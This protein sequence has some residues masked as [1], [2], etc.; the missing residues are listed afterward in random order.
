MTLFLGVDGGGT[1][2]EFVL[3]EADGKVVARALTGTTYHLQVGLDVAVARLEEGIAAVC[4]EAGIAPGDLGHAFFGLPAFGE[5]AAIDPLLDAACGRLLGHDRYACDNDMVCGWAGSLA[6]ADG[7]NLVAGTGS[8]GYGER[9]GR[10]ARAGGWGEV[11]SDEGSAYWIAVQGLNLFTR[12]SDGRLTKTPLWQAFRDA[13]KLP[14]DLDICARVMGDRGM[15]RD[16]I[17]GLA[18]LVSRAA[19]A[20]DAHALAVLDRAGA[21]LAAIAQALREQL[22]FAVEET[23]LLSWSGG[24]LTNLDAVR[25]PFLDSLARAGRYEVVAP[26]HEPGVGA[27]LYAVLLERAGAQKV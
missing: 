6:C 12:M 7:I 13:L 16:E 5:D 14:K 26:L 11:F 20:G 25:Q 2:T 23:V 21:E 27:A 17:A 3:I 19:Q 22:G 10:K 1:K 18:P 4:G 8:I 24:V 15:G 9:R